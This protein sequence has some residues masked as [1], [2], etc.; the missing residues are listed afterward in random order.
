[1]FLKRFLFVNWGNIPNL[2]FDFGPVNLLSGG[3]GSG[4]TTA[5]DALQTIMT[6]AHENLFQYNPGQD[7]TTQRGRGG[8]RVRTLASYALG[9]DDGSYAR[10]EPCDAYLAAIFHPTSGENAEPFSVLIGIRAWLDQSGGQLVA[11]QEDLQFFLLPG[12]QLELTE[13]VQGTGDQRQVKHLDQMHNSL[14]QQY[15][16]RDVEKYETKKA[17]LRRLFGALKGRRDAVTEHEAIAAA[18]AFS[19]FM[20]YKPVQSINEFV[21]D[22]ILERKDLGEA[23]RSV[24]SQLKT[25][26][27]MEREATQL[28]ES[29]N[30][31]DKARIQSQIYIDEWIELNVLD[32]L[33]YQHEF[34]IRQDEFLSARKTRKKLLRSISETDGEIIRSRQLRD[35]I[36]SQLVTL[37]AQRL[38]ILALQQKDELEATL[39]KADR[40]LVDQ[41]RNL[42]IQ[43]QQLQ[44]NLTLSRQIINMIVDPELVDQFPE[45][46][47]LETN[48]LLKE[49]LDNARA[50]HIE[51]HDLLQRD[52]TGDLGALEQ[53]LDKAR[54][55]QTQHNNWVAHWHDESLMP[56]GSLARRLGKLEHEQESRY[57]RLS[58]QRQT[59]NH[60]IER[61]EGKRVSY[62][63]YVERALNA[64]RHQ[65]PAADPRVLCDHVD[66]KDERW[67]SAIEGYLGGA[68]FSILVE[69]VHEAQAISIVRALSGRDNRARIIQGHKASRDAARLKL[70]TDSIIHTLEF[71]HSVARDYV[72][73]SYGSVARVD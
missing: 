57:E 63:A 25:I 50:N 37:E 7:E 47:T 28:Q 8:K 3:N 41:S 33:I 55:A 10:T 44:K 16:K 52:V 29:I 23:V 72:M 2:E 19:R 39:G 34:L 42:L 24:S 11:R 4:K 60:E 12:Q 35:N 18:R 38:G 40:E 9:C 27:G 65:C 59:K 26:H 32:Y 15:G 51:L 58:Q 68:R 69:H 71:S 17:Y 31:L 1:M 67:Q 64:I 73:A 49:L 56:G 43:D 48:S 66:V 20:A 36:H 62:P 21:R 61:L 46:G 6:A 14:I 53:D 5:A 13:L 70:D 45:L 22:E 30:V 54:V